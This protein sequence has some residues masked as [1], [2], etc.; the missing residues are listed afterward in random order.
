MDN[1]T[2]N[3][4]RK[5]KSLVELSNVPQPFPYQGSK[6]KLAHAILPLLPT[7]TET[8]VE[9]FAGSAAISIAARATGRASSAAISDINGPLMN[10]WQVI[11]DDPEGLALQYEK[12][13]HAQKDD[14]K[15]FFLQVRDDFNRDHRPYQLLYLLN[16]CVKAAV[17]Y[18]KDGNFNQSADNRRLG[19]KPQTTRERIFASSQTMAG[20][21]VLAGDYTSLLHQARVND[22]VYMDPPYQGVT[23]VSDH[24]YIAGLPRQ[25][26]E[27]ELLLAVKAGTSFIISYDAI[28]DDNK[29]GEPLSSSLGLTHIHLDAGRSSQAT[30]SGRDTKTVESLYLSPSLVDRLGGPDAVDAITA[31]E[32]DDLLLV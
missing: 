3:E 19:A 32:S 12:L 31:E 29:Y 6:R 25:E 15:A 7:G 13:W 23:N 30:L 28:T 9:P 5:P 24:R 8:L 20:S 27:K 10:L 21:T 22:V 18:G 14:P 2:V 4:P 1:G 16:R 26:F 11:L 17:R